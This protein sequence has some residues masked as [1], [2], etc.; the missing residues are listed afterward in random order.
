MVNLAPFHLTPLDLQGDPCL[1]I[2]G[3]S[4]VGP[5]EEL[6]RY[7]RLSAFPIQ[8]RTEGLVSAETFQASSS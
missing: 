4:Q 1:Q 8:L 7:P 3:G 5:V 6:K 2:Q